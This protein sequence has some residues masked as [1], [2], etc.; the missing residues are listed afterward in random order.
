MFQRART[1]LSRGAIK[2]KDRR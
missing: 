1:V 2:S